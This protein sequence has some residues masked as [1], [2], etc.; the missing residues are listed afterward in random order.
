M[1]SRTAVVESQIL[2]ENETEDILEQVHRLRA[3]SLHLRK[4]LGPLGEVLY[5]IERSDTRVMSDQSRPHWLVAQSHCRMLLDTLDTQR[6][7]L[8]GLME[9]HLS[10]ASQN[11]NEVMKT[12]TIVATIFVPLTFIAGLYGMNFQHMPE[13]H[14]RWGYPAALTSMLLVAGGMCVYFR[15]KRWI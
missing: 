2:G 10:E 4:W 11:L 13:L 3:L 8:S 7:I 15:K 5:R 6:D 9:L 12:L 14:W 1:A